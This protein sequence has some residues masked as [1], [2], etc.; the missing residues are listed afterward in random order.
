MRNMNPT[1]IVLT[2]FL[3]STTLLTLGGCSTM[4]KLNRTEKGAI[5]GTGSGALIGGAVG[6]G[7]GAILG[8]VGGGVV[9]GVIGHETDDNRR[10]QDR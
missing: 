2:S 4:D 5:I 6:G 7:T 10:R 8:G 3:L 9:G 1:R